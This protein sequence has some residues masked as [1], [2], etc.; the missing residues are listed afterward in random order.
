MPVVPYMIIIGAYMF[1]KLYNLKNYRYYLGIIFWLIVFVNISVYVIKLGGRKHT[2]RMYHRILEV[3][4][5]T[6]KGVV[7]A[8]AGCY[9]A[10]HNVL[11]HGYYYAASRYYSL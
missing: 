7:G 6:Q 11:L 5:S 3:H 2:H 8:Y 10:P 4:N 1:G 9:L